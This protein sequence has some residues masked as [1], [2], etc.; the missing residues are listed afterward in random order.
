LIAAGDRAMAQVRFTRNLQRHVACPPAQADGAT[1]RAVLEAVF[2]AN[3]AARDYVF[4]EH[5][6]L[7]KHMSVYLNG[8]A[9]H[10]RAGL[11]DG[12]TDACEIYVMQAL[13]GG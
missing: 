7:R 9:V 8:Q 12:V 11:S 4:D 3:P 1:V 13:S 2:A 5:G 6:K 10:D